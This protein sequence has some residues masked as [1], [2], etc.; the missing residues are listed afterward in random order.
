MSSPPGAAFGYRTISPRGFDD[1]DF[2]R[3]L[4]PPLTTVALDGE[5]LGSTAF[6]LLEKRMSGRWTR[7]QIVLPAELVVRGSTARPD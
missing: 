6:E 2:A 4:G 7:K 3:V 5:L 1:M